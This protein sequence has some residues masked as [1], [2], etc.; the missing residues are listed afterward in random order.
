V[1]IKVVKVFY[2]YYVKNNSDDEEGVNATARV[3]ATT[4]ATISGSTIDPTP[5]DDDDDLPES[6]RRDEIND[7]EWS[8]TIEFIKCGR[9][10]V[11]QNVKSQSVREKLFSYLLALPHRIYF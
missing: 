4:M 9:P 10:Q 5:D 8:K 11:E 1:T 3:V 2:N 6:E 7:S